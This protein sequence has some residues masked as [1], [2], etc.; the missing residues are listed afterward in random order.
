M[1]GLGSPGV[2]G[3]DNGGC[4]EQGTADLMMNLR[5]ISTQWERMPR[6]PRRRADGSR[7]DAEF[8][9]EELNVV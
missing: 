2:K 3:G 8:Q 6:Q 4:K 9:I 5:K 1:L 7:E